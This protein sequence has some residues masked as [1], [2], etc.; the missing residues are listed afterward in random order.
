MA[1]SHVITS[2]TL[3]SAISLLMQQR[4]VS[5]RDLVIENKHGDVYKVAFF[6]CI[7]ELRLYLYSLTENTDNLYHSF[8]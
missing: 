3:V 1:H 8:L 2:S 4:L 6:V 7:K 5:D